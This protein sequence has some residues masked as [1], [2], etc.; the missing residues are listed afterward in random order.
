MGDSVAGVAA[1]GCPMSHQGDGLPIGGHGT[2][3]RGALRDVQ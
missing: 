3:G 1:A 2:R